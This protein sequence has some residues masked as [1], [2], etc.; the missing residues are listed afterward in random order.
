MKSLRR[1]FVLCTALFIVTAIS[2]VFS[3]N[4]VLAT[5]TYGKPLCRCNV[6]EKP[7]IGSW[8]VMCMNLKTNLYVIAGQSGACPGAPADLCNRSG[9]EGKCNPITDS[10]F[11]GPFPIPTLGDLM[12]SLIRLFFFI[13]GI[14]ALF[15]LLSGAFDWI[16]S[17]GDEEAIGKATKKITAAILGLVVM[18]SVLTLV[19]IIEQVIFSGTVCL[20]VS[21]PIKLDGLVTPN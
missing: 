19:I 17:A 5:D 13:S 14:I 11:S 7:T 18:V 15:Y 9:A 16:R 10:V 4:S 20:G 21:C 6:G 3:V 2:Q 12:Q 1:A 8:E